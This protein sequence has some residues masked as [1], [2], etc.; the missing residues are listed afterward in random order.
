MF[1]VFSNFLIKICTFLFFIFSIH[2][3]TN[4]FI[5]NL[6]WPEYILTTY[7]FNIVF[8]TVIYYGTYFFSLS[9]NANSIIFYLITTFLKIFIFFI[10]LYPKF[11]L[12]G[13]IQKSEFF[14][15]IIPYS[16]C[17]F[18]EIREL[19]TFLNFKD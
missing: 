9:S 11:Y 14:T 18:V 16:S 1:K 10:F 19:I 8:A 3:L 13:V 2:I 15:F 7:I 12:D 6:E 4:H 17:L 5:F